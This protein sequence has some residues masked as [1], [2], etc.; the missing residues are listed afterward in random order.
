MTLS[1]NT[2]TSSLHDAQAKPSIVALLKKTFQTSII[3]IVNLILWPFY[4]LGRLIWY[5]P[6]NVVHLSQVKRYLW[7]TW[8]V[9]PPAPGLSWQARIWLTLSIAR[10]LLMTPLLGLAWLLDELLYGRALNAAAVIE[11]L[12]VISGGRSGSTQM[13]RYIEADPRV[14][15]PNLL[16]CMLPYLWLWQLAP[17]TIGRIFPPEKVR[18]R[19]EAIMPPELLERH[20]FDPFKADTFDGAFFSGHLNPL[21]MYLG[22]TVS[23]QEFNFAVFASHERPQLEHDFVQL[24]DRIARKQ[25]LF[26]N[27]T[28]TAMPRRFF[29]KGH[30]LCAA[31][32]L[33]RYYPDA[34]FLTVIRDPA[35]RLQSGINYLRV[36]PSDPAMGPPPWAWLSASLLQTESDYCQIE[37]AW[38]SQEDGTHRCVVRFAE[39]VADL[40]G[41]IQYVY[42]V[43]FG[44][45]QLPPHVPRMHP[46]RE[47][48][49]YTVD[50]SLAELGID[51]DALRRELAA[52]V[53][54]CQPQSKHEEVL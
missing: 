7:L 35:A 17:H 11:P 13:T 46:P 4:L 38:Y 32:A 47:R 42:Q 28:Q 52:Y 24:I 43:C 6:P 36:N 33:A 39:F 34:T 25:Q 19:L 37:Q 5:R 23:S 45:T 48:K 21:A 29:I 26:T 54:W 20:E 53:A 12:F 27:D 40:E 1:T 14:T 41:T 49:H 51:A 22:P 3:A 15:A 9:T 30:F 2:I 31:D 18:T 16:Q 10:Q 50:H 44:Q 8:S